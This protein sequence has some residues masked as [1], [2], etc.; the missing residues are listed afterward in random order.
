MPSDNQ[1]CQK[2]H[3]NLGRIGHKSKG[4]HGMTTSKSRSYNYLVSTQGAPTGTEEDYVK[5][6]FLL[7]Q[8]EAH[9]SDAVQ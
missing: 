5:Y 7:H 8:P 1:R 9:L 4:E 6:Q 2:S 3:E